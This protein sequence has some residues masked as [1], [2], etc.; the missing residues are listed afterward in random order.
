MTTADARVLLARAETSDERAQ[1]VKSAMAAG[2][3][4]SEIEELLD[5][6]DAI[7]AGRAAKLP[8]N[9]GFPCTA[10][11]TP[12]KT[13]IKLAAAE[14]LEALALSISSWFLEPG[15]LALSE[16][17]GSVL[18]LVQPDGTTSFCC[19]NIDE[20]MVA[21][22]LRQAADQIDDGAKKRHV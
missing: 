4:L 10:Q 22:L 13:Q 14:Q 11:A 8:A 17:L 3:P 12:Q 6:F 21:A 5:W 19:Q 7:R 15:M 20:Q 2:M 16:Q 9:N 18:I 1:A